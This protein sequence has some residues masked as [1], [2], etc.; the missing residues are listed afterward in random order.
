MLFVA[1]GT[2]QSRA[3]KVRLLTSLTPVFVMQL[4]LATT[5]AAAGNAK[6]VVAVQQNDGRPLVDAAV[7]VR[8]IGAAAASA[9][10]PNATPWVMDQQGLAF[11]PEVIVIPV[12]GL[13]IFPNSDT[14][15]H[16]VYSFSPAK[17][18][19]LPL[20]RGKPYPPTRFDTAGIVTL[21]CNIHDNMIGWILVTDAPWFGQ[22]DAKGHWESGAL[23]AGEYE[24][25]IWHPRLRD[26]VKSLTSRIKVDPAGI[27]EARFRFALP[28]RPAPLTG[29]SRQWDY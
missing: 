24:V 19:Q 5:V 14:V 29:K 12:G 27:A 4:I 8:R 15:S 20:Y 28:M 1:A 10:A 9:A 2:S 11:A 17:R 21:G 3:P 7:T 23:P 22:T 26:D 13:V 16:Q 25:T 6:L 18:F